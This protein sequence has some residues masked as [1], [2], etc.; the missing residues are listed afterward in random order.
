M[1]RMQAV[2]AAAS[3]S[4]RRAWPILLI[5]AIAWS[6][7]SPARLA[8]ATA[9]TAAWTSPALDTWSYVNSFGSGGR[10][11]SPTFSGGFAIDD[12]TGQ[13]LP[14]G[15]SSPIRYGTT[16]VAFNTSEQIPLGL[17]ANRYA[18]QSATLTVSLEPSGNGPL[19]YTDQPKSAAQ[20]LADVAQGTLTTALPFELF[21]VGFRNGYAGFG[22]SAGGASPPLF[23]ESTSPY[24]SGAYNLYPVVGDEE[25]A[26]AFVDVSN[27][28][29]G[30]FSATAPGGTTPAFEATPWAIGTAPLAPGSAIAGTTTITFA[31]DLEQPGVLGYMQ[32]ALSTGALGFAVS[33]LHATEQE[34]AGAAYP[35]WFMKE[36][37]GVLGGIAPTLSIEY[38]VGVPLAGDFDGDQSVTGGDFLLWQR[39]F[40]MPANPAGSGAD[41]DGD[42][43]VDG[44]D[45]AIWSGAYGIPLASATVGAVPEPSAAALA[46][47][48][49]AALAGLWRRGRRRTAPSAR[50]ARC[51][52][53][54][55][56]L[57]V[58]IAIIGTLA[59]MLLPAVQAA[60]EAARRNSCKN[61]LRQ[62]GLAVQNYQSARGHLP[63]P[64][65]GTS[66]YNNLGGT[67]VTLLPFLEQGALY[68]AYDETKS[69]TDADNL[70][71][72]GESI[73]GYLCPSMGLPRD[74]PD[75][76]CGEQ[77]APGS[78]VISSRTDYKNQGA[79]DGAFDNPAADGAYRL[80]WRHFTD[81]VSNTLLVGEINYGHADYL[82]ADC[83]GKIE[84]R[85]GDVA[86]AEGYWALA[87]GHMSARAPQLYNNSTNWVAPNSRLAFRSDHPGGVQF[88]MCDASV[89]FLADGADPDVRAALVTRA[90]E[91]VVTAWD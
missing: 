44:V 7:G 56:E 64:K 3:P 33:S 55:V 31:V 53:T 30:G 80:D 15:S 91:E 1:Q 52:F 57:L 23:R 83:D 66:T 11:T 84:S 24:T 79:L 90:G 20:L 69:V 71:I 38:D 54:L 45:L 85:W 50:R 62:I 89:Q 29:T 26:G 51:G 6:G 9:A 10:A 13:F 77:L 67:L 76:A 22:L 46:S 72:T 48:G 74:V 39:Q 42:G 18:I 14:H 27:N 87:W 17:P 65:L 75:R 21:G 37:V 86:W 88:V 68:A 35:N 59:A 81:G 5:A 61:N 36:S 25:L 2:G 63:P 32:Q 4:R 47:V 60:R 19:L 70:R 40:G 8:P 73:G 43:T 82:W 34:G 49:A 16:I 28:V 12:E 58:S 78:Y 41:G